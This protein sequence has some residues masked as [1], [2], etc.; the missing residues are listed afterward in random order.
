MTATDARN[1]PFVAFLFE[2]RADDM[3][4]GS[5][6]ECSGLQLE[7]E[8]FDY[9]EGGQN[10]FLHKLP[11]L[12]KQSNVT[13]KRGVVDSTL[14]DWYWQLVEGSVQPRN[15]SIVLNDPGGERELEWRLL[16]ALPCKW[17]GPDLNA[18]QNNL[19]V[20]TLEL[21]YQQLQRP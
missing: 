18:A 16:G 7:T 14:W 8:F 4:L 20:E 9:S 2:I 10:S 12:S 19:A 3:A 15:L 13:L 1:D 21:C 6:S 17:V 11:T 5:F